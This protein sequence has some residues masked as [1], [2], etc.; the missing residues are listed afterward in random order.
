MR[1]IILMVHTSLDGFVAGINSELDGFE[2]SDENLGFVY[3]LTAN[4]DAA[5][6]GRVSYQLLDGYW[7]LIKDVSGATQNQVLFS[8]WYSDAHKF[9]ISKSP[10]KQDMQHTTVLHTNIETTLTHIKAGAGKDIII[11]GSPS[12]YP[13]LA[14]A[15]L[16]DSYW[17]FINPVI[18][19]KGIPIF[20]D[21]KNK[22][23]LT[24]V[25]TH[26]FHNG[27]VAINYTVEK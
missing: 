7:P 8:Q 5:L 21:L 3:E 19:G 13:M 27:E 1:K 14:E 11:F 2:A 9:V 20:T 12:I 15:G 22:P 18:F 23:K 24:L 16:I 26:A 10:A 17:V 6:F 25:A 4:A